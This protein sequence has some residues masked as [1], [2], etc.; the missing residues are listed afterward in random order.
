SQ[1]KA[2][3]KLKMASPI[4]SV[5]FWG[6]RRVSEAVA[7]SCASASCYRSTEDVCVVAIVVAEL[8]LRNV[9]RQILGADLV[10]RADDPALEDRP[11]AFNRL[12]MNRADNVFAG[13][14]HHAFM[15]VFAQA[16]VGNVLIGRQQANPRRNRLSDETLQI[17]CGELAQHARHDCTTALN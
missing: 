17:N 11:D 5:I 7:S 3:S 9:Q 8:K 15:R 16:L 13:A 14:V 2:R 1:E 12:R 4:A 6:R 10:E